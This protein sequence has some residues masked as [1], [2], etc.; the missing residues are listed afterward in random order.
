MAAK[1]LMKGVVVGNDITLRTHCS[2]ARASNPLS[3]SL[4]LPLSFT[5]E[6]NYCKGKGYPVAR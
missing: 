1:Y 5:Y 6:M 2:S 4:S 3:S